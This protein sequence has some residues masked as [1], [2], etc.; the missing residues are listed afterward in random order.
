MFSNDAYR[1]C[2]KLII[3]ISLEASSSMNVLVSV[4]YLTIYIQA[5][6]DLLY[7]TFCKKRIGPKI[8][9]KNRTYRYFGYR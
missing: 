8:E 2:S 6:P 3:F 9:A 1:F 5:K 4:L 7:I